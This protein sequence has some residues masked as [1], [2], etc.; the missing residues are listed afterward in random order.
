MWRRY[1]WLAGL[2]GAALGWPA[3]ADVATGA[4]WRVTFN[5]PD[6]TTTLTSLGAHEFDVRDRF[7]EC[8]G[9]L[10]AGD[11]GYLATY[12]LSGSY[13]Q[14]GAAGPL[15]AAISNALA[16]GAHLGFVAGNG[17]DLATNFWPG[18]S[19][20]SLA[21]RPGNALELS[22]APP[23][24]IMHDKVGAFFYAATGESRLLT[25]SWNFTAAASSQQWNVLA[26]FR[27]RELALAYSNELRQMLAGYFHSHPA[28]PRVPHDGTAF[29]TAAGWTNGWVRFAPYPSNK[30]GGDNAQMQITNRIGRAARQIVFALNKQ[31]RAAVTD[32]LIAA[33]DRGV[34]VHGVI[35]RSDRAD[36]GDAS[37]EQYARMLD[38]ASYAGTNRIR[39]HE[40][41]HKST[42][43]TDFDRGT[44][45]LVHCKYLVIDPFGPEPWTIHGSA[46]W[47]LTALATTNTPTSNDENVLFVPDGGVAQ[48]FLA[49]FAAMTGVAVAAP[50]TGVRL[51]VASAA[52]GPQLNFAVPDGVEGRLVGTVD[53]NDWTPVWSRPV[54]AG[55]HVV[56]LTNGAPRMFYRLEGAAPGRKS[57]PPARAPAAAPQPRTNGAALEV[58]VSPERLEAVGEGEREYAV[59]ATVVN[60]TGLD[61][62]AGGWTIAPAGHANA[63]AGNVAEDGATLTVAPAPADGGREFDLTY[64]AVAGEGEAAV[65]NSA[66]CRLA[67]LNPR[68]VDFETLGAFAY[69]TNYWRDEESGAV[70]YVGLRTNLNGMDWK[71]FNARN[72]TTNALGAVSARLRHGSRSLPGILESLGAFSGA[73]T[74][75]VHYKLLS[76][77]GFVTF[78][79]EVREAGAAEWIPAGPDCRV[80]AGGDVSNQVLRLDVN[81]PGPLHVRLRTTGGAGNVLNVDDLDIRPYG[82][83]VPYLDVAGASAAAIGREF[84][85]EFAV[86]NGAGAPREW[87]GWGVAAADGGAVPAFAEVDGNLRLAFTPT[88]ADAGRTFAATGTVSVYGG[89]YVYSTNW[90]FVVAAAPEFE[91][92]NASANGSPILYTNQILDVWTTNVFVGGERRTNGAAY[93]A[94]WAAFPP[95]ATNTVDQYNRFRI[96]GGLL[97]ADVGNHDL[98]MT[99]V[100]ASNGLATT[101]TL[102]FLVL[103]R[104][105]KDPRHLDFEEFAET[106]GAERTVSL[107]GME[108]KTSGVRAGWS[109]DDVCAGTT[110]ARFECPAEGAAFLERPWPFAGAGYVEFT[111][112]GFAGAAGGEVRVLAK[113]FG[114]EP[115]AAVGA[116]AVPAGAPE[117]HRVYLGVPADVEVW[118]RLEASGPEG[119]AIDV[120]DVRIGAYRP[121]EH[122]RIEGDLDIAAGAGFDLRFVPANLPAGVA[123]A[124][125]EVL[126]DGWDVTAF[127]G[128]EPL[129]EYRTA[130]EPGGTAGTLAVRVRLTTGDWLET[131]AA[132]SVAADERATIERFDA[133]GLS[134]LARTGGEFVAFAVTNLADAR[135]PGFWIWAATNAFATQGSYEIVLPGPVPGCPALFYGVESRPSAAP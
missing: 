99:L 1:I 28:K 23:T 53:L 79:V 80:E 17:V 36:P 97:A 102:H 10:Q 58:A 52:G 126:R 30:A 106:D 78:A 9:E 119:Q 59:A 3:R 75:S 89:Q 12:T 67:V 39:L 93:G 64:F 63:F 71:F 56:E 65:S 21:R 112:A 129:Y 61:M 77:A 107:S 7:L 87:S 8:L 95:F 26:E 85:L 81:R 114:G 57:L 103:H 133:G 88:P 70:D 66:V 130:N 5:R 14:N 113:T 51:A 131:N 96:G 16:R 82:E 40:A 48:A 46:N 92:F 111:C 125:L 116:A 118:V 120:D 123:A 42:S 49:Q 47:T 2:V 50:E 110:A 60:S 37:Y 115:F 25:A 20:E 24:G 4:D 19:L 27:N 74:V 84:V 76:A 109:R 44:S 105:A 134:V 68:F 32:Q 35:P 117:R 6:Q 73:G 69:P 104:E 18:C 83:L 98:S 13:A 122:L 94:E 135:R 86:A 54:A 55:A 62:A 31:T 128:A 127:A 43:T 11:Q 101:R 41:Y 90:T 15:L 72:S 121:E 34:E 22:K 91:L 124:E 33:C 100:D 38:P 108:W 132:W 29:R 45:D